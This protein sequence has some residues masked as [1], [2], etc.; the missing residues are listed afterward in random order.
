[1]VAK[2]GRPREFDVEEAVEAAMLLFW[3]HGF[4]STSLSALRIEM[5]GLS[6]ASFY[7][8]FSSKEALFERVVDRY[9]QTY[10]RVLRSLWEIDVP[11][12]RA[13]EL[14]LRRSVEMQTSRK[15]PR[16]CLVVLAATAIASHN[17][18]VA[19]RA[20]DERAR[21]RAGFQKCFDRAIASGDLPQSTNKEV[22]AT[23]FDTFLT[24]ISIQAR[25][26]TTRSELNAAVT[27]LMTIFDRYAGSS[28]VTPLN[29]V[30]RGLEQTDLENSTGSR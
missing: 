25:D 12:R 7:A 14:A 21:N 28:S 13:V 16:G 20:L 11:P 30:T 18:H 27:E 10:G 4:E 17:E 15:H 6:A 3:K 23:L 2:V 24:G 26:G 29:A 1:M 8:A 9:V 19:R 22:L 5:G